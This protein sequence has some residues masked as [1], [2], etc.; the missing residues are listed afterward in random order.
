MAICSGRGLKPCSD[1]DSGPPA[2]KIDST[3]L[4]RCTYCYSQVIPRSC[5]EL[6]GFALLLGVMGRQC[7]CFQA[8]TLRQGWTT[9]SQPDIAQGYPQSRILGI[10]SNSSLERR[11]RPFIVA[12]GKFIGRL[13]FQRNSAPVPDS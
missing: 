8:K 1:R 12:R 6:A 5:D 10:Q 13:G 3:L 4:I 7:D 9:L 11:R 2:E